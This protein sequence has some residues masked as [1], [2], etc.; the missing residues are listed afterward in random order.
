MSCSLKKHSNPPTRPADGEN[1]STRLGQS[2]RH[3]AQPRRRIDNHERIAHSPAPALQLKGHMPPTHLACV[4]QG[5]AVPE[6]M[7]PENRRK[8]TGCG[9]HSGPPLRESAAVDSRLS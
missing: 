3:V 1:R 5:G 2:S 6:P 4:G 9:M 8:S 7:R